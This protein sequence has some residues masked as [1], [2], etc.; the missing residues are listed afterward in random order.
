[1]PSLCVMGGRGLFAIT[2][3]KDGDEIR[4]FDR[5]RRGFAESEVTIWESDQGCNVGQMFLYESIDELCEIV[6]SF[7]AECE[8]PELKAGK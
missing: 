4:F 2:L 7:H 1:M 5:T 6:H 8:L 3:Y